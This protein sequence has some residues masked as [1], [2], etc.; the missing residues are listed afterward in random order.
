M[1]GRHVGQFAEIAAI[2]MLTILFFGSLPR[3]KCDA[4]SQPDQ[5]TLDPLP[6]Q[7][8]FASLLDRR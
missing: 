1:N 3:R 7:T 2:L 4:T 6:D 8:A 5:S